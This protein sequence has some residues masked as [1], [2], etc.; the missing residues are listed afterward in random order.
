MNNSQELDEFMSKPQA[1]AYL[2]LST[3]T[4]DRRHAEGIGP[5]RIKHGSKI[6]YFKS[7]LNEWLK[8]F[9]QAPVRYG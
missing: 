7:S 4:L 2:N 1:A 6:G 9:E 3:R 5:R 8:G